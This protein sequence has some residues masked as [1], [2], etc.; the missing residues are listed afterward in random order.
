MVDTITTNL[1]GAHFRPPAKALLA[2]LPAGHPL[3]LRPEPTNEYDENAVQVL[4]AS[5]TLSPLCDDQFFADEMNNQ[6]QGQGSDLESV[7]AQ[8]EW[9]LGFLPKAAK[10]NPALEAWNIEVQKAMHAVCF[11]PTEGMEID[12]DPETG[13]EDSVVRSYPRDEPAT[14][15]CSLSFDGSGKPTVLIPWPPVPALADCGGSPQAGG[16][17]IGE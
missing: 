9:H 7:M 10:G 13:A 4:L 17:P 2:C 12:V 11:A 8:D 6:L 16:L 14:I 3:F 1:V 15:A 5:C